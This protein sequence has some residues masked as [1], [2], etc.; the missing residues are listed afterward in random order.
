MK[1]V[2]GVRKMIDKPVSERTAKLAAAGAWRSLLF[3]AFFL[4]MMSTRCFA[5][6]APAFE[7]VKIGAFDAE[8]WNGLVF[9]TRAFD[10]PAA[11]AVRVGSQRGG[12]FLDGNAIFD[13]VSEVGPHAPD[14]SYCRMAWRQPPSQVR[15][16]LEW[17]RVN[18]TTV[19]GRLTASH[20]FRLVLETYFPSLSNWGGQGL[21]HVDQEDRA[22]FGQRF[23]DQVFGP[24]AQF[25]VMVDQ[26]LIGSGTYPSIAQLQQE[27]LSSGKLTSS[28]LGEPNNAGIEFTTGAAGTA[29]FV[30]K[31]GWS[32]D[33]LLSQARDLLQS[34]KIDSILREKSQA[35]AQ[36][37]PT[38][39]GLFQDAAHAIGNSM[40]WNTL[41]APSN[42]LIFPS[43]SRHWAHGWGGW[44][45]GEWDCFF[46]ALLT[47]L[48]SKSETEAGVKA[49]LLAQTSTGLVP[50]IASGNGITPDRSQPPVGSYCVWKIYQRLHDRQLLE[51]AYPRLKKWHEWW[52]ANRGDGQPWRDGNRD[53]LLEWGSDR[54]SAPS[55]GGRGYLQAAKWESGMDDSPMWDH[56]TYNPHTYTMDLDDVGLNSL[57][58]LDA[59]CLSKIAL[60]LGKD[61]DARRFSAEYA[62]MKQLVQAKLWNPADGIYENRYWDGRFSKRL[63]PTN[64][65]PLFAGIATREQAARMVK[66]HLLN[67]KEFWG[68]YVIPTIARDDPAFPGQFYWRGDIWGPTNYMVYEGLNRY[69]FDK[70]ALDYAEKNYNLFMGDWKRNQHDD[71]QYFA[72]G[73]S[74]GGDKHY[75][76]GA[77]LCLVGLEQ[78]V[79]ANPWD[80]LR[81]GALEPPASGEFHR[82]KLEG[83]VY[84]V[85][86]GP[87]FT[88]LARDGVTRFQADSGVVVRDY[89][90]KPSEVSFTVHAGKSTLITTQEFASGSLL[91][92]IDG[93]DS[94]RIAVQDGKAS[95]SVP[96]GEHKVELQSR[97]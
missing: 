66:E 11:F 71:E 70:V 95:F 83:H 74:A 46:G 61:E 1:T 17:S 86:V 62:H 94:G 77:L 57:Y 7:S 80:N 60:I 25:V 43:I 44:V 23:F 97:K 85:S 20:N 18:E 75:T 35:Y 14:G 82:V 78:Y 42:N 73:G 4:S 24:T 6:A 88:R 56:T 22:I 91:V 54:G 92:K 96:A 3:V 59:E 84:D 9:L 16:T 2:V 47:S 50:N 81:F 26:P 31:V 29:H 58:A 65:Y 64:F 48:E 38:V 40:F 49:I 39:T 15:V 21:Y 63:S 13:A 93:K 19:V 33:A 8:A 45:V 55:I 52:F 53:G 27:M 34:G 30:A 32:R 76:W 67:P 36:E 79:D 28:L 41:Y 72:W 12:R 37:R 68:E 69:R 51:W 87:A 10:Q 89:T 5:Q 90:L